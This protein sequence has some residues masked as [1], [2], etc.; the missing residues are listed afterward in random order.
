MVKRSL[1]R[2]WEKEQSHGEDGR[3]YAV[4]NHVYPSTPMCADLDMPELRAT[5]PGFIALQDKE[6]IEGVYSLHELIRKGSK[7]GFE[8]KAWDGR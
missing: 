1:T 3:L 7:F 6:C 4:E 5:K 8:L 2:K